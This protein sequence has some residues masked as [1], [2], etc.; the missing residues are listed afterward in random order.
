MRD[1]FTSGNWRIKSYTVGDRATIYRD[2]RE[3]L[4]VLSYV[5]SRAAAEN[6]PG[7]FTNKVQFKRPV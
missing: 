3:F 7:G 1:D 5:E 4:K 6:T 2:A